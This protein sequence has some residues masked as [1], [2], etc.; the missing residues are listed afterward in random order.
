MVHS[1]ARTEGAPAADG[2]ENCDRLFPPGLFDAGRGGRAGGGGGGGLP[3]GW[4]ALSG[5]PCS[6]QVHFCATGSS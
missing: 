2:F 3:P 6:V 4:E 5:E 1:K